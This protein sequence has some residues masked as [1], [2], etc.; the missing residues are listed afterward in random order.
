MPTATRNPKLTRLISPLG[1]DPLRDCLDAFES[2]PEYKPGPIEAIKEILE[3]LLAE[4]PHS[5]PKIIYLNQRSPELKMLTE[6]L[7]SNRAAAKKLAEA[8]GQQPELRLDIKNMRHMI[9]FRSL[10][11]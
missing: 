7:S 9:T 4:A 6:L 1:Y 11:S 10:E 5:E 3:G 2:K 8:I